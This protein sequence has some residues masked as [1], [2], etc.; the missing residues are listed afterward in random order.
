V[1]DLKAIREDPESARAALAR[2]GAAE[3]LDRVLALDEERRRLTVRVEALRAEQNRGSKAVGAAADPAE[4][5]RVI[6][7]LRSVAE[8][9]QTLEPKLSLLEQELADASALL[10]N[11]LHPSVP[12]G[13]TE[14]DNAEVS[15]WGEPPSFDFEPKDHLTLGTALGLIDVERG[16][17][18][19]G[20][21]F[22]Y[23]TGSAVRIQFAMV[24]L[25]LDF[26][27]ARGFVPVLPPVLVR[28]EAL[29]GTGFL[30]RG[31]D[32][33]YEVGADDLY[34]IGTSE[35]PLA[36][37]HAGEILDPSSLPIRYLGYSTCFR[38]EAGTHGKDMRGVFRVHQFDK[39]E[40]FG[41]TL[42]DQS[43]EEHE[44]FL[45][46]EEEWFQGLEIPYRVV[47]C[48]VGE[49]SA[50]NAKRYDIEAWFPGQGRYREVTSASNTTD[51]QA[52]RLECR[53]RLPEGIRPVHTLN[54]TLCAI[55][56]TLVALLENGQR[57]DGS[58][59]MPEAL[60]PYLPERDRVLLPSGA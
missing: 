35:V 1:L 33:I 14:D 37:M 11:L 20:S 16:A 4:R 49:L 13:E 8:E 55:G 26:G 30:P 12:P 32:Q 52:R 9:L 43:W 28:E 5:A 48:C 45:A 22:A 27:Q 21:R 51:Y 38:R 36:S 18:T 53:V 56:R 47:N 57:A 54:G 50:S 24:Q 10:P 19:S 60:H 39:L 41:F 59:A 2:R 42:P 40:M 44:R 58:V 7:A 23:L 6:E 46:W 29:F 3:D 31:A 15:R 25:A 34:L 17:R